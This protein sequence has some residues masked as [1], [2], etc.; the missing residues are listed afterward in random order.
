MFS[1]FYSQ[2]NVFNIYGS[3]ASQLSHE[4][5]SFTV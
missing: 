3:E 4:K 2:F 5:V 1:C